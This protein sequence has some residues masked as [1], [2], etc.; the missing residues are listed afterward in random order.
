MKH[1]LDFET[2]IKQA[3]WKAF[4]TYTL[5]HGPQRSNLGHVVNLATEDIMQTEEIDTV[6]R[7][8][9]KAEMERQLDELT[10]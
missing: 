4:C 8:A 1:K 6:V 3:V 2:L 9:I 7:E 5:D 10:H